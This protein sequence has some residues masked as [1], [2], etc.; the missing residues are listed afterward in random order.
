MVRQLICYN[1]LNSK[2]PMF[3]INDT[4]ANDPAC[5]EAM[6][7]YAARLQAEEDRRQQILA[8]TYIPCPVQSSNWYISD[9]D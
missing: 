3:L 5:Q 9:R 4:A 7:A 2:R 1:T 6:K 8:G